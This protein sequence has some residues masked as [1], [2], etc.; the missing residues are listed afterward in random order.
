MASVDCEY[1]TSTL[2]LHNI[3]VFSIN[4]YSR[5]FWILKVQRECCVSWCLA[6]Y[7]SA[8]SVMFEIIHFPLIFFNGR[9]VVIFHVRSDQI[10]L[11]EHCSHFQQVQVVENEECKKEVSTELV[12]LI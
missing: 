11:Y 2:M 9:S 3:N 10:E 12:E 1:K 8:I 4:V 6:C 7:I 5:V